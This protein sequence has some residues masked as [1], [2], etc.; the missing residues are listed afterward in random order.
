MQGP[1][2]W[3]VLLRM[4]EAAQDICT[5][6]LFVCADYDHY[7]PEVTRTAVQQV[8]EDK[9]PGGW[10]CDL[11]QGLG[12]V[13]EVEDTRNMGVGHGVWHFGQA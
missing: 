8:L 13:R 7:F 11:I 10:R 12:H 3:P 4:P 5:P 9:S 1:V 6:I 2:Q